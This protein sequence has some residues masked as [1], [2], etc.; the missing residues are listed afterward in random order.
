MSGQRAH[1]D[2]EHSWDGTLVLH[3]E[4]GV[5]R[6]CQGVDTSALRTIGP[7][8]LTWREL[9]GFIQGLIAA[10]ELRRVPA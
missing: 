3:D 10:E 5:K 4:S 2:D 9:Y 8:F 1:W 6:I 7:G